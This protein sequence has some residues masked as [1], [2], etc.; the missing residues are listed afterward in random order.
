MPEPHRCQ[1]DLFFVK[2]VSMKRF[3]FLVVRALGLSFSGGRAGVADDQYVRIYN[4]IQE[5]DAL[6]NNSSLASQ[7]LAKYSEAQ[8]ALQNFR[9]F[10]A[11]WNPKVVEFRLTYLAGKIAEVSSKVAM[12][13]TNVAA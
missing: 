8:T 6:N 7:A 3:F 12:P 1:G 11:D 13:G 4:L 10:N 5:A 9:K 2:F